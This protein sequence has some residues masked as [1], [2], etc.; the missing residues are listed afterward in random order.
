MFNATIM[1]LKMHKKFAF[2][3]I[4]LLLSPNVMSFALK[5][6]QQ[7]PSTYSQVQRLIAKIPRKEVVA[8]LQA[9]LL[10]SHPGRRVGSKGHQK[11]QEYLLQTIKSID[12]E[13]KGILTVDSFTPDLDYA[14]K[15]YQADFDDQ[16][17]GKLRPQD[18]NYQ[19]WL[20][21]TQS[22]LL[23]L[24][25]IKMIQG[26][27]IIWEKKGKID[28]G[29]VLIFGAHYDSLVHDPKTRMVRPDL[30]SLGAD[31]NGTGVAM[32]LNLIKIFSEMDLPKTVQVVFFDFGQ[33]LSLGSKAYIAKY[34]D[35]L[36]KAKSLAYID[37]L[38]L[39]HDSK[40]KD[41]EKRFGNFKAY[42][43]D[44]S[45]TRQTNEGKFAK[46]F[47]QA[48][49][50]TSQGLSFEIMPNA[51]NSSN[52]IYFWQQDIPAMV[53]SQNWETDLNPR[54]HTPDDFAETLNTQTY[55]KAFQFIAGA[56]VSLSYD[57]VR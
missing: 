15:V 22:T 30:K 39:G 31:D 6:N 4:L 47:L 33:T 44:G 34:K 8:T 29:S 20:K 56:A 26:K 45:G 54:Y 53:L 14:K 50:K 18:A 38:M 5:A 28:P 27:N 57:I 35:E 11:A 43:G 37:M 51:F 55:Y 16:I 2:S 48:G 32:G 21:F 7:V 1:K 23:Y 19:H 3:L 42:L 10:N 41:S 46:R 52:H 13:A 25:S 40:D 17:K 49:E 24:D 9:F 12:S 36:K